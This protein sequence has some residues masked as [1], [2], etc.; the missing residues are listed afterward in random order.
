[1][2]HALTEDCML[3]VKHCMYDAS[4][5]YIYPCLNSSGFYART[6][7]VTSI[8]YMH[9]YIILNAVDGIDQLLCMRPLIA[10]E[11]SLS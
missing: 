3:I 10:I 5:I 9:V 1:M 7:N 6:P 8:A 4:Y 11:T 2:P